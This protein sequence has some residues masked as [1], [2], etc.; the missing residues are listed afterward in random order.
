MDA[1]LGQDTAPE[2]RNV[3]WLSVHQERLK[4]AHERARQYSEQKANERISLLNERVFCPKVAL[5][6]TVYLRHRPLGRNKIQDAWSPVVYRVVG[7]QGTTHTVEPVEG[8]PTKRVHRTELRP[9][10]LPVS[11]QN[12]EQV[13][14][15]DGDMPVIQGEPMS[16]DCQE[17][18][19]VL[20]EEVAN[21]HTSDEY[22]ASVETDVN[23]N[24]VASEVE[25]HDCSPITD[26]V[27]CEPTE[28]GIEGPNASD[29]RPPLKRSSRTTAGVHS[30]PFHLPRSACNVVTMSK[31]MV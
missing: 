11:R 8:G 17:P 6:Q 27:E 3:D 15:S 24:A 10:D 2:D 29:L 30:N 20:L 12:T 25:D 5:G 31:E 18:D 19:F 13:F 4:Q 22:N 9:C 14:D 26:E 16:D 23:E 28:A 7:I 21:P 1:L